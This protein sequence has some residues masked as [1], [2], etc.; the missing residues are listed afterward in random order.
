MRASTIT[1]IHG[2]SS[3]R[4]CVRDTLLFLSRSQNFRSPRGA[5]AAGCRGFFFG[6]LMRLA[7]QAEG[8][9]PELPHLAGARGV[10]VG[11]AK[12]ALELRGRSGVLWTPWA[13][14]NVGSNRRL[15]DA[16][17]VAPSYGQKKSQI[18]QQIPQ[19]RRFTL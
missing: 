2:R 18:V 5:F 3:G 15:D 13:R 17:H 19:G 12:S 11:G 10:V 1:V 9:L 6:E 4:V 16:H 8:A 7:R 14:V